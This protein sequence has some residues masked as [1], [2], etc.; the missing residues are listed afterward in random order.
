MIGGL[1]RLT[2]TTGRGCKT[3]LRSDET[4][5]SADEC[6]AHDQ[7]EIQNTRHLLR[8]E[9]GDRDFGSCLRI[10]HRVDVDPRN[11]CRILAL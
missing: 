9:F 6:L 3:I 7:V 11:V 2:P 4:A 5:S 10:L 1:S 8:G